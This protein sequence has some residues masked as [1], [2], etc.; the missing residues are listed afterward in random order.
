MKEYLIEE[1]NIALEKGEAQ[2]VRN[3][4]EKMHVADLALL[5]SDYNSEKREVFVDLVGSGFPA[6]VILKFNNFVREE[7]FELLEPAK[8]AEIL[9]KLSVSDIIEVIEDLKEDLQQEIIAS[10]SQKLQQELRDGFNYPLDSAGR[11]MDKKFLSAPD[12]W[13][14]KQVIAFCVKNKK[15]I[16][17]N[18]YGVFVIDKLFKPIGIVTTADLVLNKGEEK[19]TAIMEENIISFNFLTNKEELAYNFNKYDLTIA[20]I[21]NNDG[22]LIGYVNIDDVVEVIEESAEE[23]ILRL[24]GVNESDIFASVKKTIIKRLPW[25]C[26]NLITAIIAS[27]VISIFDV[28]IN[29]LVALA[30]LMPIIASMGGNAGTQTVTIAVRALATKEITSGN[31]LKII[32][33]EFFVGLINGVFFAVIS[34]VVIMVIYTDIKLALLFAI[35]TIITL[36]IAGLAGSIIPIVTQK[37]NGDPAVSSSVILTTITDV[38]AFLAFLGL[39][40]LFI[41]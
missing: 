36:G 11:L 5:L 17:D 32:L 23:D 33:K 16:E 29:K 13:D 12:H 41:N 18:L 20:P 8:G 24:G 15:Y 14:V 28:T 22:R 39:A 10:F 7:F 35:S 31:I 25:L 21:I 30:V 34:F 26:V 6:E 40:T 38:I 37:L 9:K 27:I 19:I 3:L 4:C 2:I 1:F